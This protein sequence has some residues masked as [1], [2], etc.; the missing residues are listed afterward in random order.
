MKVDSPNLFSHKKIIFIVVIVIL[1]I[2]F[3]LRNIKMSIIFIYLGLKVKF[4][5]FTKFLAL[6]IFFKM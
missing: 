3:D 4:L 1:L 2:F 5:R 6:K